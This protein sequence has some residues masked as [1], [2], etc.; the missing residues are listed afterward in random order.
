MTSYMQLWK[1][2]WLAF[3]NKV[4]VIYVLLLGI[5]GGI[6]SVSWSLGGEYPVGAVSVGPWTSWPAHGTVNIDPYSLALINIKNKIPLGTGE[7]IQFRATHDNHGQRLVSSCSYLIGSDV[8]A[9][10]YWTMSFYDSNGKA[11]NTSLKRSG[12]TSSE[13]LRNPD[14]KFSIFARTD[15]YPGNWI[16][17][18]NRQSFEIILRLYDL[19]AS[20]T[21]ALLEYQTL[22]TI[23]QQGCSQ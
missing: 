23:I 3:S 2:G 17:L 10:R 20:M 11:L 1:S 4:L 6:V 18:E 16:Q 5:V 13:V 12:Y 8:P 22:P 9:S 21:S 15:P 7:G 19:P 14:G